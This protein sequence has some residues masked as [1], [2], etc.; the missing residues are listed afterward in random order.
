[1]QVKNKEF[2]LRA[3]GTLL[4]LALLVF[5]LSQQGWEQIL[6]AFKKLQIWHIL[7]ALALTLLS[8]LAIWL[9]WH[10]LLHSGGTGTRLSQ[11]LRITLAGLFASNFLPT[12]IGGDLLRLAGAVQMR[13]DAATSTASLMVDRLVGMAGM[14]LPLPVGILTLLQAGLPTAGP[15][16]PAANVSIAVLS[17]KSLWGKFRSF[18]RETLTHF[19][20]WTKHPTWLLLSLGFTLLHQVFLY[21]SIVILLNGMHQPADWLRI[22]G[23]WSLVYFITLLPISINGYGLQEISTTLLFTHLAGISTEA[24]AMIALLV[25]SMQM[26]ASLPGAFFL[27][28]I[29]AARRN[30]NDSL[31]AG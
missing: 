15:V 4:A 18:W 10:I 14:A 24:S 20:H 1:M 5:V 28:S 27:P 2:W 23:V 30:P 6:S 22:A 19:Q 29:A 16:I 25:R 31:P 11:S 3:F 9:R 12:T 13:I 21:S 7:A 17:T 26:I 8:R